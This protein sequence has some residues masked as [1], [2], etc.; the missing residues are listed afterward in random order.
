MVQAHRLAGRRPGEAIEVKYAGSTIV[1]GVCLV[2]A[3][4]TAAQ[5]E[6]PEPRFAIDVTRD[7]K[8]P[9]RDGVR[10]ATPTILQFG[11]ERT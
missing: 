8:V 7:V 3:R 4:V 2:A 9:M 11:G 10:L 1:I 6:R 5:D